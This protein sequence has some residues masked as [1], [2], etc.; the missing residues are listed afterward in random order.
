MDRHIPK[1]TK[2][3]LIIGGARQESKW[4]HL[5]SPPKSRLELLISS[6]NVVAVGTEELLKDNLG[7]RVASGVGGV[8]MDTPHLAVT[9]IVDDTSQA[10]RQ[11]IKRR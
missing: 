8:Q 2:L 6:L 5:L 7:R 4:V 11:L 10:C 3:I 9:D 1:S